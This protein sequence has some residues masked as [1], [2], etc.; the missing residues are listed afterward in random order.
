[1]CDTS[2]T[3][4]GDVSLERRGRIPG[5]SDPVPATGMAVAIDDHAATFTYPTFV[6]HRS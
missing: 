6:L 1:M 5:S 3:R 2:L 4:S